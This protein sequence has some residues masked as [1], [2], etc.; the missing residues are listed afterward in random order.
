[1]YK[2]RTSGKKHPAKDTAWKWFSLYIRLR[3]CLATTGS[4]ERCVCVTCNRNV[5]YS[6]IQAGHAIPGRHNAVLLDED[7][8]YG[9]CVDCN[10]GGSGERQA[11]RSFLVSKHGEAW[12]TMKEQG[13]KQSVQ[14]DDTSFKLIGEHYRK[15][16]KK[17]M[18][19]AE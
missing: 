13:A 3:D 6:K 19:K 11:F 9:Q 14:I 10:E 4:A 15:E 16:Y 17:L 8:V 18:E 1:M 5:P 12:M 7:I 2:Y